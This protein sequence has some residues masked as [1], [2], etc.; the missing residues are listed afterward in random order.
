MALKPAPIRIRDLAALRRGDEIEA[1]DLNMVR[2]RGRV[3]DTAPGLGVVWIRENGLGT[4]KI[5][6]E[7]EFSIW[8]ARR[9]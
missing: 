6:H 3:E 9:S 8:Q 2:H 7:E 5:S 4:R 1:R